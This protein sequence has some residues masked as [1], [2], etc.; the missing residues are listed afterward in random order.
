MRNKSIDGMKAIAILGV[1]FYHLKILTYGYLGVDI[2][3]VIAG[4]FTARSTQIP[5]E[6]RTFKYVAFIAD[7]LKRLMPLVLIGGEFVWLQVLWG[8]C[9]MILRIYLRQLLHRIL[10]QIMFY[11]QLR[12]RIT[13]ML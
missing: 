2:F 6:S 1:V 9:R 13:G 11:Q 12:Q 10:W 8:C 4:Y 3:F 5:L 7:R